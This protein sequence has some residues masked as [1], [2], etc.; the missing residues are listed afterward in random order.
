MHP[1]GR[2]SLLDHKT[3]KLRGWIFDLKKRM[4]DKSNNFQ[5]RVMAKNKKIIDVDSIMMLNTYTSETKK[6]KLK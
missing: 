5:K 6:N 2:E 4:K 1:D 3:K